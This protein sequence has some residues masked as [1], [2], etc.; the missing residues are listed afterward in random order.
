[1]RKSL[2]SVAVLASI[3]SAHAEESYIQ[4][5]G[6]L[7]VGVATVQHSL[8]ANSDLPAGINPL[9]TGGITSDKYKRV[10]TVVNGGMQYSRL[11]VKGSR[12]IGHGVNVI[13]V[14]EAGINPQ[15]ASLSDNSASVLANAERNGGR[16]NSSSYGAGSVN[17]QIFG[18]QAY[19]GVS[20]ADW[21]TVMVGRTYNHIYD[22]MSGYDPVFKSDIMSPL[23]YSGTL[24]G[25]GGVTENTRIDNSIKYKNKFGPIQVGALYKVANDE[26]NAPGSGYSLSLGYEKD[27]FGVQAVY[28]AF[29]NQGTLGI[30][31]TGS[32]SRAKVTVYD[33]EALLLAAKYKFDKATV[34]GGWERYKLTQPSDAPTSS[35]NYFGTLAAV[36]PTGGQVAVAGSTASDQVVNV[37]FGGADYNFTPSFNLAGGVY[38]IRYSPYDTTRKGDIYWYTLIGDY[39]IN[40]ETDVYG[41]VVYIDYSGPKYQTPSIVY[42]S[43]SLGMVGIRYK[44]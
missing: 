12:D 1:M 25:G 22:V 5:Y 20:E 30:S 31:G 17:G 16:Y 6:I 32:S 4:V 27:G 33:T 13:G 39:K 36:V 26:G 10:T 2:I 40:K 8:P 19:V 23:G 38:D 24:G 44:F 35:Y 9:Q 3:A 28:Q 42:K 34:R 18:R 7:D 14:L 37:F 11:G 41:G 15:S 43:N 29:R 21:G